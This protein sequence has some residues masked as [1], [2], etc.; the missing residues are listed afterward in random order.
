MGNCWPLL[1][2]PESVTMVDKKAFTDE[3]FRRQK[4]LLQ[5]Y[6]SQSEWDERMNIKREH[7]LWERP[8]KK[9]TS[10]PGND[11]VHSPAL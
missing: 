7:W 10:P 2:T 6:I 11:R 4:K 3:Y 8:M 9:A 5:A 1:T